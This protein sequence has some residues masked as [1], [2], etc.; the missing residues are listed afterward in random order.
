MIVVIK[1][2]LF[3]PTLIMVTDIFPALALG[4]GTGDRMAMT[5]LQR[6]I[7]ATMIVNNKIGKKNAITSGTFNFLKKRNTGKN[8]R[9]KKKALTTA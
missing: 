2:T 3:K 1:K 8:M 5:R 6:M 4:L 9:L 7:S